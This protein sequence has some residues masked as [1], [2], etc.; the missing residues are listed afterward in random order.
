MVIL[1]LASTLYHGFKNPHVK[2]VF[3]VID[4]GAIYLL[5]AGTYTPFVLT[6]FRESHPG[7]SWALFGVVWGIAALGITLK[8]FFTGRMKIFSTILYL[9]MGWLIVL[10][11]KPLFTTLP[12]PA[13]VW[14]V[15]GGV[16]YSMGVIFYLWKSIPF[17][18]AIWHLFVLFACLCH[19][20]SI[21][22]Y[23]LPA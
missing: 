11:V 3:H 18:H 8:I 13:F 1:F 23:M 10:A 4:H 2:H 21:L 5:I 20:V 7:W 14:L 15:T 6:T 22:F 17:H 12:R 16:L 19:F 9:L